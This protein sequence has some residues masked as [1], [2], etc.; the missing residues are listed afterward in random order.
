[1]ILPAGIFISQDIQFAT[2]G[3]VNLERRAKKWAEVENVYALFSP[4]WIL[5]RRCKCVGL[6]ER[7]MLTFVICDSQCVQHKR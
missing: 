1:M 7:H 2:T 6:M 5:I 3:H 4:V